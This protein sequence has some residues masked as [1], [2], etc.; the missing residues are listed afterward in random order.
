L[1]I[2]EDVYE[3]LN[4]SDRAIVARAAKVA[5]VVGRAIQQVNSAEGLSKLASN[6]MTITTPT[7]AQLE[8]FREA[9]Q[10]AVL[11]WLKGQIGETWVDKAQAAVAAVTK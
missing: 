3:G 1:L 4:D 8:L 6:G 11:E 10:P 2:N 7:A 9:A 5:G